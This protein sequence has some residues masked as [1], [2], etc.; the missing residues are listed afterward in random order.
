LPTLVQFCEGETLITVTNE[1][2]VGTNVGAAG[3]SVAQIAGYEGCAKGIL[4]LNGV[5]IP[6]NMTPSTGAPHS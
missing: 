4:S 2:N 1:D 5:Q 6:G 3:G